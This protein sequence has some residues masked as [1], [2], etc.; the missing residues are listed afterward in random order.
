M[1]SRDIE[2]LR[3]LTHFEGVVAYLR[4]ELDWPIEAGDADE[5]T[6][7]YDPAEL[8]IDPRHA[9]KIETILRPC[10]LQSKPKV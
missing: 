10:M 2:K 6:F 4:D 5:V 1:K 8:G 7:D 3:R 9:V